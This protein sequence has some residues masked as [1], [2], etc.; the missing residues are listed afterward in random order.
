M[1]GPHQSTLFPDL[2]SGSVSRYLESVFLGHLC[3]EVDNVLTL[4][5]QVILENRVSSG[6]NGLGACS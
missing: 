5:A 1:Q 3:E 4:L 2:G 6:A